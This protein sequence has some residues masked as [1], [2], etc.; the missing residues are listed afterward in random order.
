[1]KLK[2]RT[3][4]PQAHLGPILNQHTKFKFSS[5]TWTM[6]IRETNSKRMKIR[7]K[8]HILGLQG[9][10]IGMKIR[11]PQKAHFQPLLILPTKFQLLSS[12]WTRFRT[13]QPFFKVKKGKNT[14]ISPLN[15]LTRPIFVALD[16]LFF[17]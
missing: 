12:A 15:R 16:H 6:V 1:M 9:E 2:S 3:H 7:Q 8:P 4:P 5:L 14:H 10:A 11:N 17:G 13:E